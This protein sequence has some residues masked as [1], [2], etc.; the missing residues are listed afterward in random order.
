MTEQLKAIPSGT[1]ADVLALATANAAAASEPR[2]VT[3]EDVPFVVISNDHDVIKLEDTLRFPLRTRAKV[4]INAADSFIDYVNKHKSDMTALYGLMG[5][6]PSFLAVID[7]NQLFIPAW[8]DHQARY[9]C[10]LSPEWLVWTSKE[11]NGKTKSQVDFARFIEDNLLDIVEPTAADMLAVSRTLEAKRSVQFNSGVRLDNGDVQ[12]TFN[13]ETKGTA[14]K[15]TLEVPERFG[16][17]IP[18][19]EGGDKYAVDARFRYRISNGGELTMWYEL[20]RPHK[21]IEHATKEVWAAIAEGTG[22]PITNGNP[23]AS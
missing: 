13:E 6:K 2:R 20:E 4:Q 10:P 18:V 11:H 22:L 23:F 16:I 12:F 7:D 15:G 9:A 1:V 8:R 19:F 17:A 5:E 14:G 21:V 3:P